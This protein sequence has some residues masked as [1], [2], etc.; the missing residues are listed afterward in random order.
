ML[1]RY[2]QK[3][4]NAGKISLSK[5]I[6]SPIWRFLRNKLGNYRTS[7]IG[8]GFILM[9]LSTGWQE[10]V[11]L[12]NGGTPDLETLQRAGEQIALGIIGITAADADKP[13]EFTKPRDAN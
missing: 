8:I 13:A 5:I 9:G 7:I 2:T 3:N 1:E 6:L 10:L 12:V 4:P 11:A